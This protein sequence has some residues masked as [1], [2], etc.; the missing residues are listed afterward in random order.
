[1]GFV[2]AALFP[3]QECLYWIGGLANGWRKRLAMAHMFIQIYNGRTDIGCLCGPKAYF[4][5]FLIPHGVPSSNLLS[6]SERTAS[7]KFL[8]DNE[9][10]RVLQRTSSTTGGTTTVTDDITFDGFTEVTISG[11]TTAT[12]KYYTAGGQRVAVRVNGILS[13]LLSDILGSSTIA[14]NSDGSGQ[15]VQLFSPYGSVNY[16]WGSMPTTFNFTGQRL[17]SQTG[18]LYYNFRYYDALSGRFVRADTMQNNERGM[19]PYAYVG[20]NPET[21][22]D[23]TGHWMWAA[24]AVRLLAVVTIAAVIVVTAPVTVPVI[25]ATVVAVAVATWAGET[26]G[27]YHSLFYQYVLHP[28]PNRTHDQSA[29][30]LGIDALGDG[31]TGTIGASGLYTG[32][33]GF[34]TTFGLGLAVNHF[35]SDA[36]ANIDPTFGDHTPRHGTENLH[37]GRKGE[38]THSILPPRSSHLIRR[39]RVS[40]VKQVTQRQNIAQQAI[41]RFGVE[42]LRCTELL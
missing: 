15:A 4:F 1:M 37:H 24:L 7:D 25:T 6:T 11:G 29:D 34:G 3:D 26:V 23:P 17:D 14:L 38:D 40:W 36:P 32:L 13:Y 20:D 42:Q 12:S 30:L 8:Y 31:L 9:S 28:D 5:T 19:D 16:S 41:R 21:K 18:L 27:V 39:E 35:M 33:I 2:V 10:K 22:S